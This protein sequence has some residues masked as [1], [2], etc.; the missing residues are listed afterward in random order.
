MSHWVEERRGVGTASPHRSRRPLAGKVSAGIKGLPAEFTG[1]LV[2]L[3]GRAPKIVLILLANNRPF[4]KSELRR[5]TGMAYRT[6]SQCL[7]QLEEEGAITEVGERG[8]RISEAWLGR[9]RTCLLGKQGAGGVRPADRLADRPVSL[10]VLPV[11]RFDRPVDRFDQSVDRSDQSDDQ[12]DQ[13]DDRFVQPADLA[14]RSLRAVVVEDGIKHKDKQQQQSLGSPERVTAGMRPSKAPRDLRDQPADPLDQ[15]GDRDEQEAIPSD[16]PADPF[17]QST[18]HFVQVGED[19]G[20]TGSVGQHSGDRPGDQPEQEDVRSGK[21]ADYL[22]Q[23]GIVG[24]AYNKLLERPALLLDPAP[25]LAWW[26]YALTQENVR[27]PTA[28]AANYLLAG[29]T[30]PAGFVELVR[31]W[32]RLTA[33]QRLATEE[34]I[35]RNWGAQEMVGYW[36]EKYPEV[37]MRTFIAMKELYFVDPGVL[38]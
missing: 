20:Q 23:A 9:F 38:S 17:D 31:F 37:T 14:D 22:Q 36:S 18:S 3:D 8:W 30:A 24:P 10:A 7:Q 28:L 5:L 35:Q 26:W 32:P 16:Q 4:N 34:M 13:S 19:F 1:Q 33:E 6:I 29:N 11:D 2:G 12:S 25:V 21:L 27:N 15:A